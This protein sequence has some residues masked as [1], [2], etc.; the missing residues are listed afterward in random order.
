MQF[1]LGKALNI[2]VPGGFSSSGFFVEDPEMPPSEGS[3][4]RLAQQLER[5][6]EENRAPTMSCSTIAPKIC[7]IGADLG[8]RDEVPLQPQL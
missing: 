3:P 8:P 2:S 1:V 4:Q 5:P 7:T 6:T